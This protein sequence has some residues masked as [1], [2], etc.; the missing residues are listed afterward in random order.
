MRGGKDMY[1]ISA[2]NIP[3]IPKAILT[4]PS[5]VPVK[6][7]MFLGTVNKFLW[8]K[9]ERKG[10]CLTTFALCRGKEKKK[11]HGQPTRNL[12]CPV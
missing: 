4:G 3:Q 11:S 2:G 8:L 9:L 1:T 10:S 12:V 6:Q 7:R 5:H